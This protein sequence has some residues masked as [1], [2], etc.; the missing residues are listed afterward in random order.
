MSQKSKQIAVGGVFSALCVTIMCVVGLLPIGAY[1]LAMT[2]GVMLLPV[3]VELGSKPA[4][5][6][7]ITTSVLSLLLAPNRES[8]IMFAAFFGYYP[9]AK[10]LLERFSNRGLEYTCKIALFNASAII[11]LLI[12]VHLLG[13]AQALEGLSEL[14]SPLPLIVT[15]MVVGNVLFIVY[16]FMLTRL[17]ITYL[18][19]L[20]PKIIRR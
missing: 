15:G 17:Y 19:Q 8:A 20:R 6:A 11:G 14:G 5:M 16:D 10:H 2:A 4:A 13:M 18:Q 12:T 1:T 3:L 9:I 7:Y